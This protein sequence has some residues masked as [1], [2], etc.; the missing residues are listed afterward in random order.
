MSPEQVKGQ[1]NVDYRADLWA[2]GCMAYECLTGRP[3]WNTD[4]GVAMTFAAIAA[5]Q[6]PMP[7]RLRPDLPPAF[8]A[9][10]KKALERDPNRRFQT[11]KELADELAKALDTPPI[12]LVS[13]GGATSSV[14]LEAVAG[15]REI[16]SAG[17]SPRG[18]GG[19][20]GRAFPP[21]PPSEPVD[22][23]NLEEAMRGG[24]D[25]TASP[26][27]VAPSSLRRKRS[28]VGSF[29]LAL[30]VIGGIGA[31][32]WFAYP[33]VRARW[34]LHKPV[35]TAT[36]AAESVSAE[37]SA[38]PPPA[39]A[40][41]PKWL[42]SIEEGQQALTAGDADGAMRKFKDSADEGGNAVAKSFFDQVKLGAALTGPC[43]MVSFSH[44]RFGYG[45]NAGSSLRGGRDVE[46]CGG[47][48]D[49]RP[50][51]ARARSRLFRPR[52]RRRK[53]HVQRA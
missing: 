16:H 25:G 4:Q 23:L 40:E 52:G 37:P 38:H 49:R 13:M 21:P 43:K 45:G 51:A 22:L 20:P 42:S 41:I 14:D 34:P 35:P 29:F 10:F 11:A 1:G 50:R 17:S 18:L 47:R 46:G 32:G 15:L 3:V 19:T 12:S 30:F 36:A 7:S 9:W 33:K 27:L 8:D 39:A 53:A 24:M 28:G 5:S 48:L 2:V 26:E 44:P 31:G 6:L